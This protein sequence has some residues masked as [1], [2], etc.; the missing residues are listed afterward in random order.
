VAGTRESPCTVAD[1]VEAGWIA[2]ACT[3]SM[4]EHRPVRMTEVRTA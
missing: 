3:L 1:A 2:E 4:H